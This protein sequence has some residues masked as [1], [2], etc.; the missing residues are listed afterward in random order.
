[1]FVTGSLKLLFCLV[2]LIP[3]SIRLPIR[4]KIPWRGTRMHCHHSTAVAEG[5]HMWPINRRR[6]S[7]TCSNPSARL[8]EGSR[9]RHMSPA[10]LGEV[11]HERSL[12]PSACTPASPSITGESP[13][14][15]IF[16][17]EKRQEEDKERY[18]QIN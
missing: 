11:M 1:M 14:C 9:G 4:K 6:R 8:G 7:S 13:R 5:V 2:P 12:A 3:S 16:R 15:D 18:M 17:R 10:S